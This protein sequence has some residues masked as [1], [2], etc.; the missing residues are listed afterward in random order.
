MKSC[1]RLH[2]WLE[3][4]ERVSLDEIPADLQQHLIDCQD[5]CDELQ[6]LREIRTRALA[7]APVFS[8]MEMMWNSI[9]KKLPPE[10]IKTQTR[11]KNDIGEGFADRF[12]DWLPGWLI[13]ASAVAIIV[14]AFFVVYLSAPDKPVAAGRLSGSGCVLA[15]QGTRR[16]LTSSSLTFRVNDTL[17]MND[18]Q[19]FAEI[20][21]ENDGKI[22]VDGNGQLQLTSEGFK[23]DHGTFKASFS[24]GREKM[25]VIVPGAVLDILGTAIYFQLNDGEGTIKLLEG[26]VEVLPAEG[27]AFTWEAETALLIR[28]GNPV[29]KAKKQTES[30]SEATDPRHRSSEY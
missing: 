19:S 23:V 28:K 7:D 2:E 10:K 13:P 12:R 25:T 24:K 16:N 15:G 4:S 5:C 20:A 11:G 14:L 30:S 29:A 3:S 6:N 9:D 22:Y 17:T 26:Q 1:Q 21:F 18:V 27:S 8:E